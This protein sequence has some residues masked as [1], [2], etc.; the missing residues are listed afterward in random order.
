MKLFFKARIVLALASIIGLPA[1]STNQASDGTAVQSRGIN[2][3][4]TVSIPSQATVELAKGDKKTGR[5][6]A[7]TEHQ[8][9]ITLSGQPDTIAINNIKGV[10]FQQEASLPK[11]S[12]RTIR[13]ESE[14]WRVEPL[15]AFKIKDKDAGNAQAEIASTSIVKEKAASDPSKPS[16]YQLKEIFLDSSSPKVMKLTVVGVD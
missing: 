13:G 5:L 8:L 7:I 1:C 11:A 6:T 9:T 3:A 12:E 2:E 10:K 14:V 4:I 15:T 16:S